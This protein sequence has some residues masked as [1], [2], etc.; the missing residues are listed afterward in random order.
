MFIKEMKTL[1]IGDVQY[2]ITDENVGMLSNL[3]TTQKISIV[4]AINELVANMN[5]SIDSEQVNILI[6]EYLA[7]NPPVTEESDPT[8]PA[9][10][11]EPN[12]PVYTASEVGALPADTVIPTVPTN[13]SAFNNDAGYLTEHQSLE[14]LA[15]ESYVNTQIAAIHTP[16][17]SGQINTHNTSTDSHNDIRLL[18]EGLT[19]RLNALADSDDTTLDQMGEV[20]AYIK[21]NKSLI[22]GIT[23]NKVNVA[24][25]IN[26]LTTN[27]TTKPLSAAQGVALKALIDA[28]DDD[29]AD[30]GHAHSNYASTVTMI[31]SGNAI[32]SISQ[33]GNTITATKGST[34]LTAHPTISKSTDTTSIAN[35]AHDNTFTAIDSITRDSN[36]HVTKVNTKTISLPEAGLH[37][38]ANSEFTV[39]EG[40]STSGA[41]LATK[42]TASG[43]DG[44]TTPTD[45]MSIAIRTPAA[46]CSGGI[47]LSIDG[48]SNYFPIVRNVNTLVTTY[49]PA[50]STIMVTFNATQT[51]SPYVTSNTKTEVTGCW[52]IA[53][54][55][56]NTK[57]S[58]GTSNKVG[59]KM[60]LVGA[61]TQNSSGVTTYSNKNCYIG[62]NNRLYSNGEVVPNLDEITA[63]ITEQLGVIENGSY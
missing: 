59:A 23:T 28:L 41:Y 60:Y 5:G 53:D 63:L 44:I 33:S 43:V 25:I 48:G 20:V 47:L 10:A 37:Y 52:Q 36:G 12:K 4:S 17:V 16:D 30:S 34:F 49:Y 42:W 26:N 11:K 35:T 55:D 13:V 6:E 56:A 51:A 39:T 32:T 40:S 19:T 8:V 31:G 46:G 45:G 58:S 2:K 18:I 9:W 3:N 7:K 24:D 54:Y 21:N 1:T 50:G 61:T 57:T 29:K 62:T 22:D 38:V 14:G 15:T 27:V